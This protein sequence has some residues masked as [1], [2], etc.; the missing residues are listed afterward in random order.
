MKII[1]EMK[2]E[3]EVFYDLRSKSFDN[4]M[5]QFKFWDKQIAHKCLFVIDHWLLLTYFILRAFYIKPYKIWLQNSRERNK[6]MKHF[7]RWKKDGKLEHKF[8]NIVL[9]WHPLFFSLFLLL[10]VYPKRMHYLLNS[11]QNSLFKSRDSCDNW[12]NIQR[13]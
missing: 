1:M 4:Y 10:N 12:I 11:L 2:F 3:T 7:R 8:I 9:L 13:L 6:K 5:N